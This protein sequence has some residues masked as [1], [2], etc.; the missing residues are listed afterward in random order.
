MDLITDR[1][2]KEPRLWWRLAAVMALVVVVSC[3]PAGYRIAEVTG[4][5]TMDGKPVEGLLIRFVPEDIK[6][7]APVTTRPP[8]AYGQ[9]DADGR[10]RAFRTGDKLFGAAT[11]RHRVWITP[12]EGGGGQVPAKYRGENTLSYDVQPGA[13]TFDIDLTSGPTVSSKPALPQ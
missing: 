3:G 8:V 9:T 12:A 1:G 11:G 5:V 10:Y 6:A 13:N 4:R 2:T 7:D